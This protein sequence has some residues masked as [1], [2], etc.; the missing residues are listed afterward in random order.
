MSSS[1]LESCVWESETTQS[2]GSE[3]KWS[4]ERDGSVQLISSTP[5]AKLAKI[6][7]KMCKPAIVPG[8]NSTIESCDWSPCELKGNDSSQ[9]R[10]KPVSS[11]VASSVLEISPTIGYCTAADSYL[12]GSLS[13]VKGLSSTPAAFSPLFSAGRYTVLEG[14]PRKRKFKKRLS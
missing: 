7:P 5:V 14:H 10:S 2:I 12:P 6:T 3:C 9:C 1:D 11:P 4:S 8:F 13:K